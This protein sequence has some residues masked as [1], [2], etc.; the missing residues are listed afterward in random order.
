MTHNPTRPRI[1]V[2][3]SHSPTAI[4]ALRWAL[5]EARLRGAQILPVHAWQWSGQHRASYAPMGTWRS[6]EE[7]YAA[8]RERAR[9]VVAGHPACLEPVVAHGPPAQV[10]LRHCQDAEMLVLGIRRPEPG[11]PVTA[12]PVVVACVMGARCPVVV[13]SCGAAPEPAVRPRPAGLTGVATG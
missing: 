5:E 9:G 13:V 2:G 7:E 1:V 10:L 3:V 11:V 4:T 6:H 12:T 8:A